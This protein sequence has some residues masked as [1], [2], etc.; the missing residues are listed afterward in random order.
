MKKEQE[1]KTAKPEIKKV[2]EKPNFKETIGD[3]KWQINIVKTNPIIAYLEKFDN[4]F[5][6][7]KRFLKEW[8]KLFSPGKD[9]YLYMITAW[10]LDIFGYSNEWERKEI[11]KVYAWSFIWEWVIFGRFQKDVE[12]IACS[13]SEVFAFTQEDLARLEKEFPKEALELYKHIIEI[14]NKRLLDSWKELANIYEATNK[15]IDLAKNWENWFFESMLYLKSLLWVDYVIYI[16]NHPALDNF[17]YYKYNTN[18]KNFGIINQRVWQEITPDMEWLIDN[19]FW[20][21]GAF[22]DDSVYAIPLKN[23]NKLKW[24]LLA[25]KR[26][27][28]ITDNQMRICKNIWTLLGS[29]VENNQKEADV[30]A[31]WMSKWYYNKW[32]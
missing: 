19:H 3:F 18:L 9:N 1:S 31:R 6:K 20:I 12:A 30:K 28:V 23:M 17:L 11:W 8:E 2:E 26:K 16:E 27:W 25:W 22:P 10:S 5:K 24:F 32:I 7:Q 13:K 14:T 29:V 4:F 15:I 21:L